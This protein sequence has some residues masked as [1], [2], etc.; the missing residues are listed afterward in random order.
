MNTVDWD[1]V[2]ELKEQLDTKI[3]KLINRVLAGHPEPVTEMVRLQLSE[4][5]RFW[6]E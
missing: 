3:H 4:Q 6:S 2:H 5:F 1:K